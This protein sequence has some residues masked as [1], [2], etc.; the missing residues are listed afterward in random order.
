MTGDIVIA[1][2]QTFGV[3]F[4][5]WLARALH[6]IE[7]PEIDRWSR[8]VIDFL[9]PLLVFHSMARGLNVERFHALLPLPLLG[10]GMM[11]F[12]ALCGVLLRK[13]LRSRDLDV[14]KTFHHLCATNNYGFLPIIIV[15]DLW[16]IEG[17]ANLFLLN[18]GSTIGY[19][20]IGIGLLGG[21]DL[22]RRLRN[23]LTPNLAGLV[24][25]LAL[26]LTG[27]TR[28]IPEVALRVCGM[29]GD[30]AVPIM[31]V[32]IGASLYPFPR[33]EDKWDLA[34]LTFVRLALLPAL[35]IGIVLLTPLDPAVR[36]VAVI[37]ALMP[38][39]VSASI[40]TRRYGGSPDFAARAAVLTTLASI[41]TIPAALLL[42]EKFIGGG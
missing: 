38:A 19:W 8:L 23:V 40:V 26:C 28:W 34:W 2:V 20:T 3:F 31:L 42:L 37:V 21:G 11:A 32:L 17:L 13:A 30:A 27:L 16:G 29:A 10:L 1:I 14:A 12:G 6:Y 25:A 9:F 18:V 7:E 39:S 5:G 33:L 24:L 41:V 36:N 4:V 15:K 35:M 22:K